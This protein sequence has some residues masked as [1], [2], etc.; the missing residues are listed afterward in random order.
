MCMKNRNS[1][2][3]IAAGAL[4]AAALLCWNSGCTTTTDTITPASGTN[5]ATTNV[6]TTTK[7]LDLATVAQIDAAV[8]NIVANAPAAIADA[9]AISALVHGTNK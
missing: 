3:T 1:K 8:S 7:G 4:C 5:A 9:Q 2:L 6:V